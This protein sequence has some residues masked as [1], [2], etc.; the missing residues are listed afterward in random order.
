VKPRTSLFSCPRCGS[1]DGRKF[2]IIHAHGLSVVDS[3]TLGAGVGTGGDAAVGVAPTS[4]THQTNLSKAVAPPTERPVGVGCSILFGLAL[5]AFFGIAAP[6]SLL[7][8][9]P[10]F[11]GTMV[12]LKKNDSAARAWNATEYP[13]LKAKWERSAMCMRCGEV[14]EVLDPTTA[15]STPSR[16]G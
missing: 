9:A 5:M 1:E 16:K 6:P 4:G 7:L 13:A 2:S 10:F 14:W 11:I 3:I 15:S 8:L 12:K